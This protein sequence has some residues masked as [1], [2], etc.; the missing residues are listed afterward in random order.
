MSKGDGEELKMKEMEYYLFNYSLEVKVQYVEWDL[1]SR[2]VEKVNV[3][4]V[5]KALWMFR[6]PN[7]KL[8]IQA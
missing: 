3:Q 4:I 7:N 1:S 8:P 2:I 5:Y 6:P